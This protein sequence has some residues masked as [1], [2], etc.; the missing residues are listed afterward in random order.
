MYNDRRPGSMNYLPG[1]SVHQYAGQSQFSPNSQRF[2]LQGRPGQV[3]PIKKS[4]IQYD[5][6]IQIDSSFRGLCIDYQ[7]YGFSFIN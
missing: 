7:F 2:P 6:F 3:S 4:F 1:Q 5:V